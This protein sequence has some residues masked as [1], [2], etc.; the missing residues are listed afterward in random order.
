MYATSAPEVSEAVLECAVLQAA[1]HE[2]KID[3]DDFYQQPTPDGK[4]TTRRVPMHLERQARGDLKARYTDQVQQYAQQL[5][6]ARITPRQLITA[7][8][9]QWGHRRQLDLTGEHG[10]RAMLQSW[11]A[12]EQQQSIQAEGASA[13]SISNILAN[14]MNKFA[15]QGYLFTE[16]AWRKF[17]AVR[18]VTDFKATKS[19]NL[20][21]DTMFKQLGPTGELENA[22]LGDQAFANQAQPYGR[23]LTIPWTHIVNDDLGMLTG[24]PLKVGQGAGLALNDVIWTLVKN[25]LAGAVNGDDGVAFFRTTSSQTAAAKKAGTAYNANKF[26]G[27]GSAL[28]ATSLQTARA[29]FDNQTDPNGNPLGFDATGPVLLHGP[30][31]WQTAT[32]LMQAAAIVYGGGAAA[33]QPNVNVWQGYAEPVMSRYM[34]NANYVNSATA[35][36]M[37]YAPAA[38]ALIEACFLNGVDTPAVLNAGPDFQFDRPGISIR[39]T[40]PF[41]VTQQNFRAGVYSA[42]A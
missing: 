21:G 14:V 31:L 27:G 10:I 9:A 1:R 5:F 20:L 40:M 15:L 29:L 2:F 25:M 13:L 28:S 36:L 17:C 42:G 33:L 41:G 19:I 32:G 8:F 30:T 12:Y 6:K 7:S 37:L 3:Q 16:Q 26:T 39:G 22:A 24:A 18:S 34:E 11:V 38:L 35:W 23:I 4:G